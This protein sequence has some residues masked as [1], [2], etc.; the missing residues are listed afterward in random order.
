MKYIKNFE[1]QYEDFFKEEE[2]DEITSAEDEPKLG[3]YVICNESETDFGY[4]ISSDN[5]RFQVDEFLSKNVGQ[6]IELI[7]D[8]RCEFLV[9]FNNVPDDIAPIYFNHSNKDDCRKMSRSEIEF[10]NS[11][12]EALEVMVDAEKY[13]L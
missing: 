10:W 2:Y 7:E 11:D 3:D 5:Y 13:N 12:R 4:R 6:I 8:D 1:S 9:Q